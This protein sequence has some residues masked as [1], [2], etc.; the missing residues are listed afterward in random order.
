MPLGLL[1]TLVIGGIGLIALLLHLTGRSTRLRLDE[2]RARAEWEQAFPEVP[3]RRLQISEDR[4]A[5]LV[6]TTQGMGL[7][8]SF[9]ADCVARTLRGVDVTPTRRGLRIAFHD[10]TAPSVTLRLSPSEQAQWAQKLEQT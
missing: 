8:W 4:H 3:M 7:I 2:A 5:A 1:L 9:G 6:E 10:F